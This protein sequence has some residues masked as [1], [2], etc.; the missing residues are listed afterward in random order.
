MRE[1][2]SKKCGQ[3]SKDYNILLMLD[4]FAL[5]HEDL[6]QSLSNLGYATSSSSTR[7][8]GTRIFSKNNDFIKNSNIKILERT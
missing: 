1:N 8:I 3:N 5:I 6:L 2:L 4:N 7:M